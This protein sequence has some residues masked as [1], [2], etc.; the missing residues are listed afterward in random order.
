MSEPR[1]N[2]T[3]KGDGGTQ[4]PKMYMMKML[5]KPGNEAMAKSI[6]KTM[7]ING[8]EYCREHL[9]RRCHI[10]EMDHSSTREEVESERLEMGLR[11]G[12]DSTVDRFC[13]KWESKS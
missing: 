5:K 12:G 10:C 2:R 9:L 3:P 4:T 13:D 11:G 8:V 6:Y 1:A 7:L